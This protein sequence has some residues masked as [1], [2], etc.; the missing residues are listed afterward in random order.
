MSGPD[1]N[2]TNIANAP[3][4]VGNA[5]GY[6]INTESVVYRDGNNHIQQLYTDACNTQWSYTDL[7]N[8]VG[9]PAAAGDPFGY[10]FDNDQKIVYLG[11]NGYVNEIYTAN[12]LWAYTDLTAASNAP[13]GIGNPMG[14]YF[15]GQ[16]VVYRSGTNNHIYQL[17]QNNGWVST[18]LSNLVGAPGAAS[19]PFGFIFIGQS[20]FYTDQKVIYSSYFLRSEQVRLQAHREQASITKL[21][22]FHYGCPSLRFRRV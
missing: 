11:V 1:R 8:M 10:R 9:A 6:A 5:S 19:D 18:D 15:S 16:P 20:V 12:G 2:A 3:A 7:T 14:Y 17:W 22:P 4:A 21:S 13:T